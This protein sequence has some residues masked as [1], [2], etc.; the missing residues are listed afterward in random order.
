[1]IQLKKNLAETLQPNTTLLNKKLNHLAKIQNKTPH[2]TQN[3]H[4]RLI[5][6]T[7][8]KF[9]K[10]E[11]ALLQKGLEY[12]IHSKPKNWIQNL[13]LEAETA[14]TQLP[15][16]EQDV[17]RKQVP[18]RIDILQQHKPHVRTHPESNTIKSIRTKLSEN[19]AMVT[20]ADKGNYSHSPHNPI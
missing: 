11:M 19:N 12:N 18:D 3:F 9:S 7:D 15:P 17:Y 1:M 14:I 16:N 8:I 13:A 10:R 4:P 20:R 2:S 6:N 5:N